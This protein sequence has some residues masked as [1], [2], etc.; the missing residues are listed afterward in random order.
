MALNASDTHGYPDDKDDEHNCGDRDE[1]R[2]QG[3]ISRHVRRG[4]R[5]QVC[6]MRKTVG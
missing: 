6:R 1:D 5:N 4:S 3:R 2:E